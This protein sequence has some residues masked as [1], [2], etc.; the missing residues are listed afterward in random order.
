[1]YRIRGNDKRDGIGIRDKRRFFGGYCFVLGEVVGGEVPYALLNAARVKKA[2]LQEGAF[3][4]VKA[5]HV[6][7]AGDNGIKFLLVREKH[8][9]VLVFA[10]EAPASGN[11]VQNFCCCCGW[12]STRPKTASWER[13]SQHYFR[14]NA[15]MI[16]VFPAS[17][18]TADRLT[19]SRREDRL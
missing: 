8:D 19:D 14:L 12:T 7:Q 16:L 15:S 3:S 13:D 9:T 5:I 1:V 6:H 17:T 2:G 18:F 11:K 4:P 10:P